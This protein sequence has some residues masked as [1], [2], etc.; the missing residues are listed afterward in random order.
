VIRTEP[1]VSC[2]RALDSPFCPQCGEKRASDRTH[3]L[4]EFFREHVVEAMANL[5]G[6]VIRSLRALV[7]RPG[8]L[9]AE[10]SRG[11]RLRYL[12]PLQLFL[13]LNV[14][15]FLWSTSRNATV[16]DTPFAN[17]TSIGPYQRVARRLVTE[18]MRKTGEDAKT[19]A[20]RFDAIGKAQ[21]RSLVL[22]MVPMFALFVALATLGRRRRGAVHH[23]VFSL[24]SIAALFILLPLSFYV[25]LAFVYGVWKP[26]GLTMGR[27]DLFISVTL[28]ALFAVYLA[29]SLRR[30]YDFAWLRSL[31]GG[32]FLVAAFFVVLGLY[33]ALLFFATFWSL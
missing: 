10:F 6:R 26:L 17:H 12:P 3:T 11:V 7:T 31:A 33:R 27:G 8:L 14:A 23:L 21:S 19:F 15:F 24:H 28:S 1:C 16:F 18:K 9:T 5:D 4:G 22:S 2:G 13:L 20:A 25:A 32:A 30:A 29:F